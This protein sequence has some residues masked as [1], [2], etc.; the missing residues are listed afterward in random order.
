[1][2]QVSH[3]TC[4]VSHVTRQVSHVSCQV[5]HVT[6]FSSSFF[7]LFRKSSE[8]NQW[9]VS[10]QRGLPHLGNIKPPPQCVGEGSATNGA[11]PY[12]CQKSTIPM[13]KCTEP[14]TGILSTPANGRLL[15]HHFSLSP[16]VCIVKHSLYHI[17]T[18]HLWCRL[19][20]AWRAVGGL[21]FKIQCAMKHEM[22]SAVYSVQCSIQR[23]VRHTVSS[24][25]CSLE[26]AVQNI[27]YRA[28]HSFQCSMQ[29]AVEH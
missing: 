6:F 21:Q 9:M 25:W 22:C 8:P 2:C 4:Q 5:S 15:P 18:A 14:H 28:E 19:W 24:V 10:Y 23:A 13:C 3:F 27:V 16:Q 11:T 12:T 20:E 1:M 7:I 26:C 17:F 29:C